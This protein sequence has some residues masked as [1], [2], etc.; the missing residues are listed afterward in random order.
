METLKVL[1]MG[2]FCQERMQD[3]TLTCQ[4]PEPKLGPSHWIIVAG[5]VSNPRVWT[6]GWLMFNCCL[7]CW[8][9]CTICWDL[10]GPVRSQK[11][12]W[13]RMLECFIIKSCSLVSLP[14]KLEL[15]LMGVGQEQNLCLY[16]YNICMSKNGMTKV[17]YDPLYFHAEK[18]L[19]I[20]YLY[21]K[22]F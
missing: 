16:P 2:L 10:Q 6:S 17:R 12:S 15:S 19:R 5:C 9:F 13:S 3:H 7:P 22:Y 18:K 21:K 14:P 4:N 8:E 11:N 1:F 20:N